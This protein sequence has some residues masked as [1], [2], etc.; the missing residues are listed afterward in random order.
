MAWPIYFLHKE[1]KWAKR[2]YYSWIIPVCFWN[3]TILFVQEAYI[4][5]LLSGLVNAAELFDNWST[6]D[7]IFTNVLSI[8]VI[9]GCVMLPIFII[10]Y[11]WPNYEPYK[12]IKIGEDRFIA[13][14]LSEPEWH[15]RYSAIYDMIDLKKQALLLKHGFWTMKHQVNLKKP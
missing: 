7:L 8:F 6:W 13:N 15:D 3:G 9:L 12:E 5:L 1:A 14:K 10:A 2:L 11:I 4:E